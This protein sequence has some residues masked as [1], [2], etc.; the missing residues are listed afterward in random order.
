MLCFPRWFLLLL[1]ILLQQP[2]PLIIVILEFSF[3]PYSYQSSSRLNAFI[4]AEPLICLISA[5]VTPSI[6]LLVSSAKHFM[7]GSVLPSCATHVL[8]LR[9]RMLNKV[10][11]NPAYR[12]CPFLFDCQPTVLN[13]SVSRFPRQSRYGK[14]ENSSASQQAMH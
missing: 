14:T 2:Y 3:Y 6:V 13:P 11:R 9:T 12:R 10:P 7:N 5:I 8:H 1:A 4:A